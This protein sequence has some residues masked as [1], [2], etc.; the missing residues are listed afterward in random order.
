ME[1]R[2]DGAGPPIVQYWHSAEVPP[3]VAELMG[4]FAAHNPE[5]PY[6]SFSEPEAERLIARHYGARELAAFRACAVPA[7]QADYF[8]Y[9]A[10]RALGG[11]Y[12]DADFRCR[13]SLT[14]LVHSTKGGMLFRREPQG[15]L[16]NGFFAFRAPGH[17]LLRLALDV[18]T[19]NI[20]RR[21]PVK[22][23]TATG[24]WIFSSLAVLHELGSA[25]R[26]R[27]AARQSELGRYAESLLAA[28]GDYERVTRAFEDVTIVPF[29][30]AWRWI[31]ADD[32]LPSYKRDDSYWARW[33][34]TGK[35]IYR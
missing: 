16:I 30:R 13:R 31:D 19:S 2:R 10:V 12:V 34:R 18:A 33:P 25:V 1:R 4:T 7:M 24:P 6:R 27:R 11:V 9:C 15:N 23:N 20:E 29:R 28:V 5:L 21:A 22:V 26:A 14:D 17:P 35:S 8:R 32:E 3:D